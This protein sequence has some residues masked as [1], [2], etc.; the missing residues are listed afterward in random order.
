MDFQPGEFRDLQR[1]FQLGRI[2]KLRAAG[3]AAT[4]KKH[5]G[6]TAST[7]CDLMF[8]QG[9]TAKRMDQPMNVS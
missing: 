9:S 4:A 3:I 6:R 5:I 7:A 8:N 1:S 2:A